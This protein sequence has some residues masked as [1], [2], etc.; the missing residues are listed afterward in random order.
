MPLLIDTHLIAMEHHRALQDAGALLHD[1]H[2][3]SSVGGSLSRPASSNALSDEV[4]LP[5]IA[6]AIV[7]VPSSNVA[8]VVALLRWAGVGGRA[9]GRRHG[10]RLLMPQLVAQHV[11]DSVRAFA[12]PVAE[13]PQVAEVGRCDGMLRDCFGA[14]GKQD[15]CE[16]RGTERAG[17]VHARGSARLATPTTSVGRFLSTANVDTRGTSVWTTSIHS[18]ATGTCYALVK[19]CAGAF[20]YACAFALPHCQA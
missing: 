19:F 13:T 3:V 16:K 2:G 14:R 7:C 12:V 8:G 15:S 17:L 6:D 10:R 11:G 4:L 18:A 9:A 5:A 1:Q 20:G